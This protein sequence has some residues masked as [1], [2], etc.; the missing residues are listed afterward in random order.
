MIPPPQR[1]VK[2]VIQLVPGSRISLRHDFVTFPP[3][4]SY[5][6]LTGFS[7]YNCAGSGGESRCAY[8]RRTMRLCLAPAL[9]DTPSDNG[10]LK[11]AETVGF[12]DAGA[13]APSRACDACPF[14]GLLPRRDTA[15]HLP[16]R[17]LAVSLSPV[18]I[19]RADAANYAP[20]SKRGRSS[21]FSLVSLRHEELV[22]QE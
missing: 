14:Y 3:S 1:S 22:A 10:V 8:M 17:G 6:F 15:S 7:I 18:A 11:E 12:P 19:T 2:S 9:K 4:F 21:K 16:L 5:S 20:F 13:F